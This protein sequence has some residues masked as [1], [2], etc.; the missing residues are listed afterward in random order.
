[1][2]RQYL[3]RYKG[4]RSLISINTVLEERKTAWENKLTT[5]VQEQL[6]QKVR[7]VRVNSNDRRFRSFNKM[8]GVKD[9]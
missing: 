9:V 7:S 3:K 2:D 8:D 5:G 4:S 1:M 6:R